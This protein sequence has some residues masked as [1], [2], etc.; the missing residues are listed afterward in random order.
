M[1]RL[2]L[3]ERRLLEEEGSDD[4]MDVDAG[5]GALGEAASGGGGK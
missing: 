1:P 2:A 3:W 4:I 5:I